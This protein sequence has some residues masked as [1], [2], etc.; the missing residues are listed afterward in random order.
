MR[1]VTEDAYAKINLGL[2]VTGVREDGYHLVKMIMQ[3]VGISDTLV[4]TDL[5]VS[6]EGCTQITLTGAEGPVPAGD[7]NLVCRAIRVMDKTY[8][9]GHD[10]AVH[11]EKRIPV[12]AGMAGGSTDAAA[13]FRAMRDLF[14]PKV[15]DEELERLA[16]PLGADIPY[17]IKGGTQLA[18]GIGEELTLL[19]DAPEC[20]LV[21]VKPG[22]DIS[23]GGIYKA[24]DALH[25]TWHPDID[26]QMEA[27]RGGDLRTMASLCGNVLELVTGPRCPAVGQIEQFFAGCGALCAMMTGSGPAVFAVFDDRGVAQKS[28]ESFKKSETA[29]GCSSFLTGFVYGRR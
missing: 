6:K 10:M 5:G 18:E 23:T 12:A 24:Y 13:A 20:S 8:G 11:L 2:D 16:L 15:T 7:D 1:T 14:V 29:A 19:P 4:F 22:T 17:C 9:I 21:V 25:N 3:T 28:L 26:G 27:I